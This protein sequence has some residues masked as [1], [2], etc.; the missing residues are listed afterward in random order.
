MLV[1]DLAPGLRNSDISYPTIVDGE[2]FFTARGPMVE[3][4]SETYLWKSDGTE[5]GTVPVVNFAVG[6]RDPMEFTGVADR[7][8]FTISTGGYRRELW[9]T[10]GTA[11]GT[12]QVASVAP[13]D[14]S[15]GTDPI[16]LAG[17]GSS[18][19]LMAYDKIHG[20]ELWIIRSVVEG[21]LDRNCAIDAADIDLLFAAVGAG[22]NDPA[23]DLTGDATVDDDDIAH[24][25]ESILGTHFGD[26]NLDG[27]VDRADVAAVVRNFGRADSPGWAAGDF[28]GDGAV[29]L[30]DLMTVQTDFATAMAS[31]PLAVVAA[32][33]RIG[34]SSPPSSIVARR[35]RSTPPAL[36]PAVAADAHS[37]AG[38]NASAA[39]EELSAAAKRRLQSTARRLGRV[40]GT[41]RIDAGGRYSAGS[42]AAAAAGSVDGGSATAPTGDASP[43]KPN[44]TA[45]AARISR[46]PRA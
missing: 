36:M 18:L 25:V 35:G 39:S 44:T 31:A 17:V 23:Y 6:I 21:D 13:G 14:S 10:D 19:Y 27:A 28:N 16:L 38:E 32:A 46:N 7:L 8:Y 11:E 4:E 43:L 5:A 3:G 15:L 26:A 12:M 45:T 37:A 41:D 34:L 40:L 30:R 9:S 24:L 20:R 22:T 29:D 33:V 2:L 42:A 1:R